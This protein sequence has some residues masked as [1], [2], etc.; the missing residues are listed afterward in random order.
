M[1]ISFWM[2]VTGLQS[3]LANKKRGMDEE[4]QEA[5]Q[6]NAPDRDAVEKSLIHVGTQADDKHRNPPT[7]EVR[8]FLE[9][10]KQEGL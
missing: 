10:M 8:R 7:L 6:Q 1:N 3:S 5:E 2:C 4:D 9:A